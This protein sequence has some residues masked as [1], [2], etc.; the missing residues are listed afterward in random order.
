MPVIINVETDETLDVSQDFVDE[1]PILSSTT[2]NSSGEIPIK[3]NFDE[4]GDSLELLNKII[5]DLGFFKINEKPI[6]DLIKKDFDQFFEKYAVDN[7][8]VDELYTMVSSIIDCYQ[9]NDLC[10]AFTLANFLGMEH[11][12]LA[13]GF[14]IGVSIKVKYAIEI[15][16]GKIIKTD[17]KNKKLQ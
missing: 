4:V 6:M 7:I 2:K 13:I 9:P 17:F 14:L 5:I 1:S 8:P 15:N 11:I 16:K 12:E 10:R 3:Y